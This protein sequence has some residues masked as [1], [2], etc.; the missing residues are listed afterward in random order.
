VL[1]STSSSN[2]SHKQWMNQC[3]L[4][5]LAAFG[6][7]SWW[8]HYLHRSTWWATRDL[9]MPGVQNEVIVERFVYNWSDKQVVLVGS[10]VTTQV[11]PE[12]LCPHNVATIY[13]QGSGAMNGL[14]VIRRSGAA[15]ELI[16]VELDF[17]NRGVN[18]SLINRIFDSPF[19][20]LKKI[21]PLLRLENNLANLLFKSK[22]KNDPKDK[23]PYA[24]H[25]WDEKI[26]PRIEDVVRSYSQAPMLSD[27]ATDQVVLKLK[28]ILF[29]LEQRGCTIIF[30]VDPIHPQLA[31]LPVFQTWHQRA[32]SE[33][34]HY[35][36]IEPSDAYYYLSDGVHFHAQSGKDFFDHLLQE[37]AKLLV[38]KI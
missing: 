10:S 19:F 22:I 30:F 27:Y 29:E 20:R 7:A 18:E 24:P 8:V 33:F 11:P 13:V 35:L 12:S 26:K 21:F 3:I 34:S 6:L 23:P 25:V 4:A 9:Q 17:L 37:S 31:E 36:M 1:L 28:E 16:L 38:S 32:R 5:F 15:P 14:E 2:L